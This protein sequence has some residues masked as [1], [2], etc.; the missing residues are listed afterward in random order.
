M[1]ISLQAEGLFGS[2]NELELKKL[3]DTYMLLAPSGFFKSPDFAKEIIKK[4]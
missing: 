2:T 4:S 3:I 1:N